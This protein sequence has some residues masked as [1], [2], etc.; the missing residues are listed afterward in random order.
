MHKFLLRSLA[1]TLLFFSLLVPLAPPAF[2]ASPVQGVA[3]GGTYITLKVNKNGALIARGNDN[4]DWSKSVALADNTL[5]ALHAA[6]A[7]GIL[8]C[9]DGIE[10]EGLTNTTAVTLAL[11]DGASTVLFTFNVPAAAS[12]RVW[13]LPRP[14]CGTAA[15][16][17][18]VALSGTPTGSVTVNAVGFTVKQ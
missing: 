4:N 15:T 5:T 17:M 11:K 16:A 6:G 7:A 14:V 1:A 8:N 9:I 2:A 3:P 10:W 18:N 12:Q 13:N